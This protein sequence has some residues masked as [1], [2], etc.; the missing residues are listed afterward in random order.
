[1]KEEEEEEVHKR[2][3]GRGEGREREELEFLHPKGETVRRRNELRRGTRC[4]DRGTT[5]GSL[6]VPII[7][8]VLPEPA[9]MMH[10]HVHLVLHILEDSRV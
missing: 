4:S 10:Q 7:V 2:C 6:S 9:T 1:M 8:C 5:P 3:G